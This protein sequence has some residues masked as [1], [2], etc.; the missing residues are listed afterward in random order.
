MARFSYKAKNKK[1]EIVSN[2][3]LAV[4]LS[5]AV[6]NLEREGFVLLEIYEE[7]STSS[8][9]NKMTSRDLS[10]KVVFSTK[11]KLEFFNAFLHMYNSG[12]SILQIFYAVFNSAF[13][14]NIKNLC[15]VII[16]KIEKG[17]N[18]EEAFTGYEGV[19]GLAYTRLIVAGEASGKLDKVLKKI[20]DG[21][22]REEKLKS[23]VISS[24]IYPVSILALAVAVFLFFKFFILKVFS[25]IGSSICPTSVMMMLFTAIFK[26]IVI[27]GVFIGVVC[28]IYFNKPVFKKFVNLLSNLP[29]IN[30]LIKNYAFANF[31]SVLSLAYDAGV[32][33]A[34]S[35]EM[36]AS[37][38]T[39]K[40][41]KTKLNLAAKRIYNGC[42]VST[43]FAVTQVFSGFA[44]SQISA[45]EQSG[46]LE[47]M[48]SI[49]SLDYEKKLELALTFIVQVMKPLSIVIVGL[50]VLYVVKTGYESY[51]G[52][53]MGS[54]GF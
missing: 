43:A 45:G 19:L 10:K 51:F 7:A 37:V 40:D 39:A 35:I 9:S 26:I 5:S 29:F 46:E 1:G 6:A 24:M 31:F 54:L 53:L 34:N 30:I 22:T 17:Y 33:I 3:I 41:I 47:K 11:E 2:H 42:S 4:D 38:I 28:F 20:V 36:A 18:L 48:F 49:V 52:A 21:I 50:F 27:F 14:P 44:M 23:N 25:M 32:P 16:R 12:L 8:F 15:A 13:N